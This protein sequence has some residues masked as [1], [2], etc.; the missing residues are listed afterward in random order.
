MKRILTLAVVA[1]AL[2]VPATADASTAAIKSCGSVW[3]ADAGVQVR[4]RVMAAAK[5]HVRLLSCEAV[6]RVALNAYSD[7]SSRFRIDGRIWRGGYSDRCRVFRNSGPY[8]IE[9]RYC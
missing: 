7:T 1:G 2:V 6:R 4:L 5:P 9:M 8:A 3:R